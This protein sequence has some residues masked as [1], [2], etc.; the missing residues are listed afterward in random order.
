MLN[1]REPALVVAAIDQSIDEVLSDLD[2]S[3]PEEANHR[4]SASESAEKLLSKQRPS[5]P[6]LEHIVVDED[7]DDSSEEDIEIVPVLDGQPLPVDHHLV[8]DS[9]NLISV[10]KDSDLDHFQDPTARNSFRDLFRPNVSSVRRLSHGHN[11]QEVCKRFSTLSSLN[12]GQ[13]YGDDAHAVLLPVLSSSSEESIKTEDAE[14]A[15]VVSVIDLH[16]IDSTTEAEQANCKGRSASPQMLVP[17]S[18]NTATLAT[19]DTL[20]RTSSMKSTDLARK[21]STNVTKSQSC[22]QKVAPKSPYKTPPTSGDKSHKGKDSTVFRR[23]A[24]GSSSLKGSDGSLGSSPSTKTSRSSVKALESHRKA[25]SISSVSSLNKQVSIPK[26]STCMV[27]TLQ[28]ILDQTRAST[29]RKDS[30]LGKSLPQVNETEAKVQNER[31]L[32]LREPALVVAAIDQS[33]D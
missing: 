27:Q 22:L 26:G 17:K 19:V 3:H 32:N 15:T 31:M 24:S 16:T 18:S 20:A 4:T 2:C 25:S 5:Q 23:K 29:T 10:K 13:G 12:V 30:L 6:N 9:L 21:L 11:A 14:E 1:L 7:C 28:D 33:I 8:E